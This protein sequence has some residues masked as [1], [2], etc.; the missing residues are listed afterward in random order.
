LVTHF[1]WTIHRR[2]GVFFIAIQRST[3]HSI[4]TFRRLQHTNVIG[5]KTIMKFKITWWMWVDWQCG[6]TDHI[7]KGDYEIYIIYGTAFK[8]KTNG[9]YKICYYYIFLNPLPCL[10]STCAY[11]WF[12]NSKLCCTAFSVNLAAVKSIKHRDVIKRYLIYFTLIFTFDLQ[13]HDQTK[14]QAKT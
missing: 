8:A 4:I 7:V 2:Q 11:I 12:H 5:W 3:Q 9:C 13:N 14:I 1:L 10:W 6:E